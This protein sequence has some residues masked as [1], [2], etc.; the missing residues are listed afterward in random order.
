MNLEASAF[1]VCFLWCLLWQAQVHA[2][3]QGTCGT[4]VPS[5][6]VILGASGFIA[7]AL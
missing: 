5:L 2:D 7:K 4:P 1:L 6:A 3:L